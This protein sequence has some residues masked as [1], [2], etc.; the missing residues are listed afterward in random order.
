MLGSPFCRSN[1]MATSYAVLILIVILDPI[2]SLAFIQTGTNKVLRLKAARSICAGSRCSLNDKNKGLNPVSNREQQDH[3]PHSHYSGVKVPSDP[4]FHRRTLLSIALFQ[5]VFQPHVS[6]A[7]ASR[8]SDGGKW[9][10]HFGGKNVVKCF[11][12]TPNTYFFTIS[13]TNFLFI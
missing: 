13:T 2:L 7:K 3:D 9:A 10:R 12:N 8:A 6:F 1:S 11:S 4:F 5:S